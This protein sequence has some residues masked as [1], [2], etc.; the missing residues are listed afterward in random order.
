MLLTMPDGTT[1]VVLDHGDRA[2]NPGWVD[3]TTAHRNS[4]RTWGVESRQC[5]TFEAA[6]EYVASH[7]GKAWR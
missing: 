2:T 1:A 3:G 6:V 7:A 4:H 5:D